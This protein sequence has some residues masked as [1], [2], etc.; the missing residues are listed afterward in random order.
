MP[1]VNQSLMLSVMLALM[2]N[3]ASVDADDAAP[4]TFIVEAAVI[5]R[6]A[7]KVAHKVTAPVA[8]GTSEVRRDI[9]HRPF[10]VGLQQKDD[11]FQPVIHM[12]EDGLIA[13]F[14]I[15]S[16]EKDFVSLEATVELVKLV[17]VKTKP[18]PGFKDRFVQCVRVEGDKVRVIEAVSI[19]EKVTDTLEVNGFKYDLVLTVKKPIDR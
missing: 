6:K 2:W 3:P 18:V 7:Q 19:G 16:V 12:T 11:G 17:D 10:V 15:L 9:V 14:K 13:E 8:V 1:F 4:D 5:G